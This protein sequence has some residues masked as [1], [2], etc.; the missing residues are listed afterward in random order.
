[1]ERDRAA[2]AGETPAT[3]VSRTEAQG[4]PGGLDRDSVRFEDRHSVG[5][6]AGRDGMYGDDLLA[7]V[8]RLAKGGCL[9]QSPPHLIEQ[10]AGGRP[11]R[12]L[13]GGGRLVIG[14]GRFGGAHTG[15]NPTD[16]RKAGSKHHLLTD[17]N[18]LPLSVVLTGAHRNDV[19]QLLVLVEG[20]P[21]IAG[22]VGRPRFRPDRVQGD[23]G[24]D[25]ALYRHALRARGITPV[26][27]KRGTPHGSGLGTTRWVVER[28]LSWLHQF[29]RL[30]VRWE[31]RAD[32]H[33]AFMILACILICHRTLQSSFC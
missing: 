7:A 1:V 18:G 16:R 10:T 3:P 29:R 12:L 28:S 15:P 5:G 19:T 14:T 8:A 6:S 4:Q 31:R 26:L 2:V 20:I 27:A 30:R 33:E 23:R 25:A 17:A 22:R 13:A 11:D 21:P 32:I 9:G 24:Y